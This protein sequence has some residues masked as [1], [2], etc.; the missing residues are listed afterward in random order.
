[1]RFA[2]MLVALPLLRAYAE[3]VDTV[4]RSISVTTNQAIQFSTSS[5]ARALVHFTA[6]GARQASYRWR[7]I[8]GDKLT[9]G[10]GQVIESYEEYSKA[11]AKSVSDTNP[12]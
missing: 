6:F 11:W 7:L 3:P 4:M 5:G 8:D 10:S 1:M 12:A 9:S 2:L